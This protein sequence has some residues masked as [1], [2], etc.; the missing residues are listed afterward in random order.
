MTS[1]AFGD[2]HRVVAAYLRPDEATM[3]CG[4]LGAHGIDAWVRDEAMSAANPLLRDMVGGAKVVVRTG[5]AEEAEALLAATRYDGGGELNPADEGPD[6]DGDDEPDPATDTV[7]AQQNALAK[8]AL[9]SAVVGY[10]IFAFSV[11]FHLH[12]AVRV[13]RFAR[14]DAPRPPGTRWRILLAAALDVLGVAIWV[15]ILRRWW[16]R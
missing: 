12:S 6:S 15:M 1:R 4:L 5:D 14:I 7:A 3:L 8:A 13:W 16:R 2:E 9:T 10:L 11:V